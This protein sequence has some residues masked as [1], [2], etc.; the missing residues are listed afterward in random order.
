MAVQ[1]VLD[2][3]SWANKMIERIQNAGQAWEQGIQNPRRSPTAAMKAANGKW[4]D[5]VTRA[6]Q[7]DTWNKAISRLS[8]DQ[9]AAQAKAVGGSALVA[10]VNARKQKIMDA[11]ARLQPKVTA[12]VTRVQSMPQDTD[13]QR[14]ARMLEN[15]RGMRAIKGS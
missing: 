6:V 14:E 11:I 2:P 4:K 12:V 3:T 8:D 10:G 7:N 15:L 1:P 9:I 13:Q 5:R